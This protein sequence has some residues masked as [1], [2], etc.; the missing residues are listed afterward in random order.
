MSEPRPFDDRDGQMWMDGRLVPWREAKI[1]VLN[2]GLHYGSS[3]FEGLRIYGGKIF[4]A[5]EHSERLR[6]SA[7]M[8]G[9]TVPYSVD[10]INKAMEEAVAVQGVA[11][12]YI[13]PVVWLGSERMKIYAD[14]CV[15]HMAVAAWE[16][17]AYFDPKLFEKGI[18]LCRAD[19][20]RPSPEAAPTGSKASG[21]YMICTM[22]KKTATLKGYDDAL[23]LDYRGYVA[24]AT[25]ANVFFVIDGALHTPIADCFLNGITRLTVIDLAKQLGIEVK[26]RHIKP[27]E[28]GTAQ[29]VFL[30]G[31][32]AEITPVGA[33][34]EHRYA[35]G[36]VTKAI[37]EA[38]S[39][40][41]R[42]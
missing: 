28:L 32:A 8:I 4:K 9:F 11:D 7:E 38:Y 19:W 41:V 21:L 16:W 12:G 40:E 22:S 33:I 26:E 24:E 5:S 15:P 35:P 18:R 3:V 25:G 39:A 6:R 23:M 36:A 1:H 42:K 27:E 13:R 30:T 20:R 34:A 2:H 37:S 10:E 31:T 29:E 17:P 14:G